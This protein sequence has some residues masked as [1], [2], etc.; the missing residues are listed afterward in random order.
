MILTRCSFGITGMTGLQKLGLLSGGQKSRVAFACLSLTNPHIL[1]L[2]EP[3]NHLD[4]E[5]MDA[6]SEALQ[7]FEGGVLMVSHDVTMIQNVCTSLW[8]CDNGTVEKFPGDVKA[9]K[10]RITEQ[11]NEAGVVAKH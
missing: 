10:K 4:M 11:A 2:D 5:A 9:Y 1:V 6:L 3:S 8:V 7:K